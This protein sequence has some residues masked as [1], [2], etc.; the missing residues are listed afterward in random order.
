M[1]L[2]LLKFT[3]SPLTLSFNKVVFNIAS[4]K[5]SSILYGSLIVPNPLENFTLDFKTIAGRTPKE[6]T[7]SLLA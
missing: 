6:S 2:I 1:H 7:P 3:N 4:S 5:S